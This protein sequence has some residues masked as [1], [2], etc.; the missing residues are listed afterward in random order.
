M[1]RAGIGLLVLVLGV[2]VGAC[3]GDDDSASSPTSSG[4]E[5]GATTAASD[6]AA[7]EGA[8]PASGTLVLSLGSATE[9]LDV[10]LCVQMP[11]GGL[12]VTAVGR[13]D[14]APTLTVNVAEPMSA[15]TLV[16]T[17]RREDNSFTT[18][19]MAAS[20]STEGSVDELRV[21]VNGTAV[22]QAYTPEGEAD[23]DTK[24]E[25][26]T[27]DA[28]CPVIQPPN[29]APEFPSTTVPRRRRVGLSGPFQRPRSCASAQASIVD[30]RGRTAS[31]SKVAPRNLRNDAAV[32]GGR[33]GAALQ[34]L[35]RPETVHAMRNSSTL[36][37]PAERCRGLGRL[38]SADG[39]KN[40]EFSRR[41]QFRIR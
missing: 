14:P 13:G 19:S 8:A 37:R 17:T 7:S 20:E 12:N 31:P 5:N 34:V 33:L 40:A 28:V 30:R 1:T 38:E 23:G 29:P 26:V 10:Q 24:S 25:T 4:S 2:G 16:Y 3:S 27:V 35:V 39:S 9:M 11:A 6:P 15:S 18:H 22:E 36:P 21:R 41:I 32:R